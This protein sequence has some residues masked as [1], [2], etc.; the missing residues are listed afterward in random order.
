MNG[1][2]PAADEPNTGLQLRGP[3][4]YLVTS[5]TLRRWLL[6]GT[7]QPLTPRDNRVQLSDAFGHIRGFRSPPNR[8]RLHP[9]CDSIGHPESLG[10][11]VA[12][13]IT[14][15]RRTS[16]DCP[17]CPA[18]NN[19]PIWPARRQLGSVPASMPGCVIGQADPVRLEGFLQRL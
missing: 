8:F 4:A 1:K 11:D 13:T 16:T 6:T 12:W 5:N 7:E 3:I 9:C 2:R 14:A 10:H 19:Q 15:L 18:P 17:D